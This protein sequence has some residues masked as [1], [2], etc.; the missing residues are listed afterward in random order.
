MQEKPTVNP[1][2]VSTKLEWRLTTTHRSTSSHSRDGES[3]AV[4]LWTRGEDRRACLWVLQLVSKWPFCAAG[5]SFSHVNPDDQPD[6]GS[7]SLAAD[8]KIGAGWQSPAGS[9]QGL[10]FLLRPS[11]PCS[12]ARTASHVSFQSG[13]TRSLAHSFPPNLLCTDPR[14]FTT[15]ANSHTINNGTSRPEDLEECYFPMKNETRPQ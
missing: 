13:G 3:G 4:W 2:L 8:V 5:L 15:T 6:P 7:T 12:N 10:A 9:L 14:C 11:W 1:K